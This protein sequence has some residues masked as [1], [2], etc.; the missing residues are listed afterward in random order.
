MNLR[1]TVSRTW[2]ARL[3]VAA[4]LLSNLSAAV[5]YVL[6][7][8]RYASAFELSGAAGAAMVR[9]IGILFL[10]WCTAYVP[11]IVNPDCHPTLFGVILAQQLIGLVGES[12]ILASLPPG[13]AALSATGLRYIAFDGT[14]LALLVLAI[15]LTWRRPE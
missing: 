6:Q 10:M 2:M 7:P 13:H 15:A 5:P 3:A 14:G 4:V 11:V 8:E 12:W 1:T 9:A